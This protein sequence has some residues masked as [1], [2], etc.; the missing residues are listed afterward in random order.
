MFQISAASHRFSLLTWPVVLVVAQQL[1]FPAPAGSFVSGL[2]LGS[3]TALVALAMYLVYQANNVL[4]F[5][6][7]GLGLLPAVFAMLLIV[8]SGWNWYLAFFL[9]LICAACLGVAT[10]FLIVRR[11]FESPRLVLTVAT[12]GIA[13]LLAVFALYLPAWWDS[14]V[15]SQRLEA[16]F[17][18]RFAIGSRVF[19]GDHL[20]ALVLG[21]VAIVAVAMLLRWTRIGIAIRASAELPGRAGL[22]GIPVKAVQS[23]VWGIATVLA[24]LALFLRSG[25]YGLPIGGSLG[26]LLLLRALAALTLGRLQH[27]PTI[28]CSSFALGVLQEGIVWNSQANEA[29]AK[30]A[31][32]T[33]LI[34]V[35]ALVFRRTRGVRS[36]IDVSSWQAVGHARPI[37]RVFLALP[38]L[39]TGRLLGVLVVVGFFVGFPYWGLFGT[40]VVVRM[41]LVLMYAVIMLSL[42]ILTGWAGQLSLGQ[43][44]FAA[45]GGA[46]GAWLTQQAGIDFVAAT[47]LAGCL[48]ALF[49]LVVGIPALRMRGT[50]LAVT[51]LALE[52][53][54][55]QYFLN[56]QFFSWVPVE[57]VN[58]P[59][60]FGK[61][62]WDS[63][64]A[65]YYV[66]LVTLILACA[67][68]AGLKNGRIGRVL[69]ALRDNEIAAAAYGARAAQLKLT[70]FAISGFLAAV[71]G[72]V[73]A[74]HQ[75]SFTVTPAGFSIV[76]FIGAVVGGLGSISGAIVGSLY[77]NGSWYWLRGTWSLL[78]TGTGVLIVLLIAPAG[79]VG[80]WADLRNLVLRKVGARFG[81]QESDPAEDLLLGGEPEP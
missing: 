10:E 42:G 28:I 81:L 43:M 8:E 11:F 22:L 7:G 1:L 18:L 49:S 67:A 3:I 46:T 75:Q 76:V 57:R 20:L 71:A 36:A 14:Y 56:P 29:E 5:A 32:F 54:M 47:V 61:I 34:I 70:A 4:N 6:A 74:H 12:L 40:T 60:L 59:P 2:V 78:A 53:T 38:G 79:I 48:G 66:C 21:P 50:Y 25:V 35:V 39:R 30:M 52:L 19:D 58:R 63:S 33:G 37:P 17:G 65:A 27:L 15:Q 41:G 69:I 77:W 13:E 68:V 51:T 31:A 45:V 64:Q 23:V 9:A 80:L 55:I 26:L 24:F 62:N 44:A 72:S 16:P 73:I